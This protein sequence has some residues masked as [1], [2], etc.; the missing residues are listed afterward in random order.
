MT[1]TQADPRSW[2]AEGREALRLALAAAKAKRSERPAGCPKCH[3]PADQVATELDVW[4]EHFC[5]GGRP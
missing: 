3:A 2:P 5:V 1:D 4:G